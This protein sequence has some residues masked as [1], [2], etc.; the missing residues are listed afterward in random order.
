MVFVKEK[1]DLIMHATQ[2]GQLRWMITW[3]NGSVQ[4]YG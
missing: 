2:H 1:D 3:T 4:R